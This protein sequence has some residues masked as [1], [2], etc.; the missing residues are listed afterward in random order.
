MQQYR[1]LPN[2]LLESMLVSP[3]QKV[4]T[5]VNSDLK[6]IQFWRP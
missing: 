6:L 5:P 4:N 3:P 1:N 2:S